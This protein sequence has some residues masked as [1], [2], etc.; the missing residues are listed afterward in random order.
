MIFLVIKM[1]KRIKKIL[2][3]IIL[4]VLCGAICGKIV[5][6]IYD[7]KLET[8]LIGEKI[9]LIQA[10]AY[11]TYDNMVQNTSV[12][13]YIYYEDDGLF[14]SIIGLTESYDNV[15]KIKK[16]YSGEVI[17]SEY[18]SKDYELNQKIKEYDQ[19]ILEST[20]NEEVQKIVLEMLTLYKDTESTLTK[21]VS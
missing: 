21:I 3:P 11:S 17:V 10:G 19:K 5:Y 6:G 4:S 13:N 1:R 8:D 9:Y 16:T 20:T 7:Q 18:Y 12:H 14:K 15:E 2:M